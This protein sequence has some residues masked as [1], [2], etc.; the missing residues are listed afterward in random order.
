MVSAVLAEAASAA[1]AQE[2]AGERL[3]TRGPEDQYPVPRD[4]NFF[5]KVFYFYYDGF[6]SMTVGKKLWIILIIKLIIIFVILR[7][8]FFPDFLRSRFPD[9]R[10]RGD[11]V[12]DQLI[13]RK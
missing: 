11:Y 3:R 5:K 7:L 2:A 1:E 8:I 9:D 4:V 13:K 10:Q 6:R 12:K